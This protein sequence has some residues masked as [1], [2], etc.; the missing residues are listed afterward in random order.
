[1][2]IRWRLL[3]W[4]LVILVL[5]LG[6]FAAGVYLTMS[7]LLL[8]EAA[9]SADALGAQVQ[10]LIAS[11]EGDQGVG[12]DLAD[13]VL[14]DQLTPE[15][16]YLEIRSA[17]GTLESRS[18]N[19]GTHSLVAST[20][21]LPPSGFRIV[22]LPPLGRI[23]VSATPLAVHG[24]PVGTAFVGRSLAPI[25]R[26]LATLR[27][28]FGASLAAGCLLAAL[29]GYLFTGVLL[30]PI[31]RITR[32]ARRIGAQSLGQRL[33]LRGPDDELT[34]LAAAFDEMLERLE[35]AFAREQRFASDAAHELRTPLAIMKTD[36]DVALR[37]D[38]TPDDYRAVLTNLREETERLIRLAEDLLWLARSGAD[39][40]HPAEPLL[41]DA[42]VLEV[43][44]R[45]AAEAARN[46][47]ALDA[48]VLEPLE[49]WGHPERIQRAIFNVLDNAVKYTPAGGR[50]AVSVQDVDGH[51]T[52][53]IQDTGQGI[54][55]EHLAHIF[56]RFYRADEAAPRSRGGAGLGLAI[57]KELAEAEGGTLRVQSRPGTGSTFVFT[58]PGRPAT[59]L[60]TVE[61]GPR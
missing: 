32:T 17:G 22:S 53:A 55:A 29:A 51:T 19:L 38:R 50:V 57:A 23:L 60:G 52:I 13:T 10:R 9:R 34:R 16:L 30:Q 61:G 49:I 44:D 11:T 21:G 42:V 35:A 33:R 12:M 56:K 39:T 20:P 27:R 48:S 5:L 54:P 3:S 6:L 25:D 15:G 14:A 1:M 26:T 41:L 24:R 37:Q 58:F 31:D 2:A 59:P 4:Y 8:D 45:L 28:V 40:P 47:V 18:H 7:R 43:V 36:L 46:G